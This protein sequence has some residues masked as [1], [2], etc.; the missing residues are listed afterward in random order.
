M[1]VDLMGP[2]LEDLFNFC[3]RKFSLK[4]V[5][6]LAQQ[7]VSRREHVHSRSF[8]HCDIKPDN[9]LMGASKTVKTGTVHLIDFGLAR[10]YRNPNSYQHFPCSDDNSFNGTARYASLN[11]H[12]GA[13][14]SRRDDLESLGYV[15]VYLLAGGL[16]W[17]GLRAASEARRRDLI[18]DAKASTSPEQL[19]AGLP[20]E[21]SS[22]LARVRALGF[23]EEPD[24]G[25]LRALFRD[26]FL[27]EG[28]KD[29]GLYDWHPVARPGLH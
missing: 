23:E 6:T 17:Q 13:T 11:T 25:S 9:F 15:L 22:Y 8:V 29:D 16:P 5:L 14:P 20:P 2:S 24:Y 18:R 19:C 27:R 1:V 4:T 21:L 28:L 26:L 3:S 7:M 12:L 10:A